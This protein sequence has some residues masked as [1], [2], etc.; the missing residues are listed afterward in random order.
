MQIPAHAALSGRAFEA[1]TPVPLWP[2]GAPGALGDGPG[3]SP[4]LT[5]YLPEAGSGSGAALLVC[6][7]GGYGMLADHEGHDYALWLGSL[8]IASLCLRYRLGTDGYR[9]PRMLEDAARALRTVR[10]NA[11]AWAIDPARIGVMGSSAG[12]H[13]AASLLTHFDAGQADAA[14][15][16]ERVSSRPDLGILCYPV[17]TLGPLGHAGSRQNLLG[18]D[19]PAELVELLS[20]ERQVTPHTPPCFLW[21]TW[22]DGAVP[23]ENSL[24]FATALRQSGVPFDLHIYESGAHGL[25]L[26]DEPPFANAHPWVRDLRF[27]LEQ[28]GFGAV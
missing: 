9:H 14:D 20:N 12:G 19:P 4:T 26:G 21:H 7:G 18:D 22:E 28:R 11:A 3:H 27:W 8:G 5:P 15:P 16:I 10:A 25:G 6:P 23:V 2:A 17:I 1:R 13:L 24:L